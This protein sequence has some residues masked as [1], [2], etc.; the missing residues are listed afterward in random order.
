M[1]SNVVFRAKILLF[2]I[3]RP[4]LPVYYQLAKEPEKSTSIFLQPSGK[5]TRSPVLKVSSLLQLARTSNKRRLPEPVPRTDSGGMNR[6]ILIELYCFRVLLF[7]YSP[8]KVQ[9]YFETRKKIGRKF[10]KKLL[11]RRWCTPHIF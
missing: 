4:F 2:Y 3:Y 1:T 10:Y 6:L 7:L 9:Q 8:S 5:M 11:A